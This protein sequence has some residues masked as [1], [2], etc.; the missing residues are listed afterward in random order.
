MV[1][2]KHRADLDIEINGEYDD[3][4]EDDYMRGGIGML[5][6][7]DFVTWD[8]IIKNTPKLPQLEILLHKNQ[9]KNKRFF[10]VY[11]DY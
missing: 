3:D 9:I 6:D 5:H 8:L 1:N 7:I 11:N 10:T 4:D 2:S